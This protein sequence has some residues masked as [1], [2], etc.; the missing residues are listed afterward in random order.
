[1]PMVQVPYGNTMVTRWA[2][3]AG[4]EHFKTYSMARPLSTHWRTATCA[5]YECEGYLRGFMLSIDLGTELG[6][7]QYHYVTHDKSRSYTIQRESER[8]VHVLYG[9]GNECFASVSKQATHVVLRDRPPFYLVS[10]GDW[11]GNPRGTPRYVHRRPEDWVDDFANH[12][13]K[14][15]EAA[16]K[17]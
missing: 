12:Q 7:R 15:A 11:R 10:G 5:E 9:P 1:M 3:E 8:L 13:D 16:R 17:G 4:P 2:P 6:Q 14:L